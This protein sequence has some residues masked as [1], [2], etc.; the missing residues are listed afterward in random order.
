MFTVHALNALFL[1][2]IGSQCLNYA[3]KIRTFAGTAKQFSDYLLF[4]HY[5][6][7]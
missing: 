1:Y 7:D 5:N 4:L 6:G 2:L 3:T